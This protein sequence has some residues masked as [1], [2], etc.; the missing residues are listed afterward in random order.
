VQLRTAKKLTPGLALVAGVSALAT[1]LGHVLPLLG[2]AACALALGIA[3]RWRFSPGAAYDA[4]IRFTARQVLQWSIV[5]LGFGLPL[6]QV[7]RAGMDSLSVTLATVA[8]AFISALLFGRLLA[9]PGRLCLLIGTGTAICGGSAIAA[10]SPIVEPD[11]HETAFSLSTIFLFNVVAVV[12]FPAL[13][14]WLGLSERGF[15]LWAGTAINDTS[16]VVA[17]A[18]AWS[19]GAG[20]YASIVKLT[21]AMLI[22]PLTVLLALG[23]AFRQRRVP[24]AAPGVAGQRL[25]WATLARA[26]PW[27]I[28]CFV[29]ASALSAHLPPIVGDAARALAPLMITAALAAVGL[30]TDLARMR[31][32]GW[33]PVAL[34][35][36]VWGSVAASSLLVQHLSAR[37]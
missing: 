9:V 14:H 18:Y 27:F 26:L 12:A 1:L 30:S 23:V 20:E 29:A 35:L 24:G 33:R 32:T 5:A 6:G 8:A 4:G 10:V 34:G 17:A 31:A 13:G 25:R 7:M 36:L 21:R 11:A 19:Q 3:L 22:V 37:W 16:S 15:A 2:G 28:V